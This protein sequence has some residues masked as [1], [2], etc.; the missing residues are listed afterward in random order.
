MA[1]DFGA[2]F[3]S[4]FGSG[5]SSPSGI[6]VGT[7]GL[8]KQRIANELARP[9]LLST[10]TR[11]AAAIYDA[12]TLYQKEKFRFSEVSPANPPTFNTTQAVWTYDVNTLATIQSCYFINFM[13]Y[14]LGTQVFFV[15]RV[16]PRDVLLANQ[17]LNVQGPPEAFAYEGETIMLT[18]VPDQTYLMTLDVH[19]LVAAPTSDMQSGNRW[20]LDGEML[21]RSRAKFE[22]ATHVTRNSTMAM[23]MSPE[24]TGGPNGGPGATWRAFRAL[25]GEANRLLGRGHVRP[26]A[27]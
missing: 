10:D 12:I 23:A 16:T 21:I 20:M 24:A 4:S 17:N 9:D 8:M 27:W 11:I 15:R 2:D 5:S 3:G 6:L 22:I 26:M 1:N 14:T 7:Q 13:L 19:L 18:P 25:K